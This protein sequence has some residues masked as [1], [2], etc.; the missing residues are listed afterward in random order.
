MNKIGTILLALVLTVA[1]AIPMATPV[2]AHTESAPQVQTLLAGQDIEV[3]NVSVW[4]NETT[5][6]VTYE[7]TESPWI[8]TETHLYAGKN[9]SPTTAPGQFPYS[10]DDATSATNTTVTYEIP[11]ADI[12]SYSME[13]NRKG[14]P[15]GVMVADGTPGVEPCNDVYIAAHAVV[16]KCETEPLTLYPELTWQRSSESNVAVYPGYGA[17]WNKSDGFNIT[18]DLNTTVWDGG[19]GGSQYFT[20]YSNRSDISWAS[21]ACTQN[22]A[23]KSLTGTDLRRFQ[24]TFAIPEGYAVTG[25]TLGSVNPG[26]EDVIPM[27]DNIYIFVNEELIFWGGTISIAG[28]DPGRTHFLGMERRPTEPQNKTAFPETDGWHMDGAIPEIS[29]SLFVEGGNVLDV[30]AE[31]LWT[32]GGMHELGLTL[33]GEQTTCETETAWGNGTDFEHPNWATY[34]TYH[35]QYMPTGVAD[36]GWT[37]VA[38]DYDW[39]ARARHGGA[40]GWRAFVDDVWPPENTL[41]TGGT[42]PWLN[43]GP[44]WFEL[45]YDN[46]TNSAT[47]TIYNASDD[48]VLGTVTDSSVP[49]F[50]GLIG[51]QGKTSPEA[52]GSVVVD[53]VEVNG[54]P[55]EGDDGFTAQGMDFS[56]DLEHLTISYVPSGSFTLTGDLTF[57]WGTNPRDEGP[58]LSIYVQNNP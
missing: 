26:Y 30:F 52:A 33:Q 3:G 36:D 42:V 38:S 23:G 17:Q 21:W 10:D 41:N 6:Y 14:K 19:T 56:R 25:G 54:T 48:S 27:N 1:F 29:S 11:L 44:M 12:D 35:V 8:I 55:V 49:G 5:L 37:S 43:G 7:I 16:K 4:N 51:I 32:G 15:T 47:F 9:V 50:N 18:F 57:T 45:T 31:E 24:A 28:L 46:S 40:G 13:V 2:V 34:F 39:E 58:A 22:P 53:N 20:G